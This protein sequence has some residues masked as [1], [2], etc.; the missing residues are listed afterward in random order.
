MRKT[1]VLKVRFVSE[2]SEDQVRWGGNCNPNE[3]LTVGEVY[4]V[5]Q[6]EVHSWHTKVYLVGFEKYPFNS[7]NFEEVR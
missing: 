5:A 2:A 7:V 3:Y 4:E 1:P 6:W